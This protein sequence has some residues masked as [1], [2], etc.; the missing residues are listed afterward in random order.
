[1]GQATDNSGG[2]TVTDWNTQDFEELYAE[3]GGDLASVPWARLAPNPALVEWLDRRPGGGRALVIGCGYGDDAEELARRGHEVTAFDVAETA[4]GWCR[5]RFP[6][7]SVDYRVA[8]LF[9]ERWE[10]SFDLVV[11]LYTIQSLPPAERRRVVAAVAAPVAPGGTL[12]VRCFARDDDAP[13]SGRPWPVSRAELAWF[14]EEGL[15]EVELRDDVVESTGIRF[16]TG[17][18]TR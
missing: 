7:S 1:M 8:D 5:R 6:E 3:V 18:Y 17:V 15:A 2:D 11:E 14:T 16:F 4:I 12:F 9:T 13:V 10:T